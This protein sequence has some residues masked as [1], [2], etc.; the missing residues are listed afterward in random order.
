[1]LYVLSTSL[2][3]EQFLSSASRILCE[4]F[5]CSPFLCTPSDEMAIYNPTNNWST[6]THNGAGIGMSTMH[7]R[8]ICT[9]YYIKMNIG[10][11]ACWEEHTNEVSWKGILLPN[12]TQLKWSILHVR[13]AAVFEIIEMNNAN[14]S[15]IGSIFYEM[16]GSTRHIG[17]ILSFQIGDT[18][19]IRNLIQN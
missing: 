19:W 12:K 14:L 6:Y 18:Q 7:R 1:M 10:H 17:D 16:S 8:G 15:G 11:K 5:T 2:C 3:K 9:E 4:D 13:K